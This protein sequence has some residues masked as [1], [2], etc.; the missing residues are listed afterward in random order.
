MV[1]LYNS[2]AK[3]NFPIHFRVPNKDL[4]IVG[5]DNSKISGDVVCAN[6]KDSNDCELIF[7]VDIDESSN[8]Y[9]K[10]STDGASAPKVPIKELT[11]VE[12]IKEFTLGNDKVKYTRGNQT[13]DF[14]IN[15]K[16]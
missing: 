6:F 3:G 7:Y 14:T 8:T 16:S 13:F 9:V 10:I 15:G 12:Q 11:V 4:N 2:G 5:K 1:N